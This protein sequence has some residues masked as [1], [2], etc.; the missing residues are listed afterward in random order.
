MKDLAWAPGAPFERDL[1][2]TSRKLVHLSTDALCA[3]C[4]HLCVLPCGSASRKCRNRL[5]R[6]TNI[7]S[8][9]VD[10]EVPEP[11]FRCQQT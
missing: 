6:R 2:K 8:S 11:T 3:P 10:G 5:G 9:I 7:A 4:M 1:L